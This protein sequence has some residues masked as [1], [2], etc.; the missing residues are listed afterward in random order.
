MWIFLTLAVVGV[1]LGVFVWAMADDDEDDG[2]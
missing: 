1:V 2:W